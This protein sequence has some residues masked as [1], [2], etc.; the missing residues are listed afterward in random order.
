M[1]EHTPEDGE[2]FGRF[3]RRCSTQGDYTEEKGGR[4]DKR[5]GG[6]N[7]TINAD[8]KS[9]ILSERSVSFRGRLWKQGPVEIFS[10][11]DLSRAL[12]SFKAKEREM[13]PIVGL[14]DFSV[15]FPRNSLLFESV[16]KFRKVGM[17][18]CHIF[19]RAY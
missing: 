4:R 11:G 15:G 16:P 14:S 12:A 10:C 2:V 18:G 13:Q 5:I 19:G 9:V 8:P 3:K 1:V 6:P 17:E 7:N